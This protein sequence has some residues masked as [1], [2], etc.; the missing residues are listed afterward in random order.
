MRI[1]IV[2]V[3]YQNYKKGAVSYQYQLTDVGSGRGFV[4][5][6][7]NLL[8]GKGILCELRSLKMSLK[9]QI[10]HYVYF[11]LILLA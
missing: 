8:S 11:S 10:L 7:A 4:G 9:V 1:L 5:V 2:S 6:G 3:S